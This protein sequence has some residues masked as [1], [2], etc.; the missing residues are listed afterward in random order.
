MYSNRELQNNSLCGILPERKPAL[1]LNVLSDNLFLCEAPPTWCTSCACDPV[2]GACPCKDC[3]PSLSRSPSPAESPTLTATKSAH[4]SKSVTAST[5]KAPSARA[6]F[7]PVS[8]AT[9]TPEVIISA[10]H[11]APKET[12]SALALLEVFAIVACILMCCIC[13]AFV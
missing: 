8:S 9:V 4:K 10:A 3:T 7:S 1:R 5:T 2:E 6:S 11:D 13:F 12:F